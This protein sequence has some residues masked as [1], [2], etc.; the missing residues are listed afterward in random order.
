MIPSTYPFTVS[1]GAGQPIYDAV[2]DAVL[3]QRL[4]PGTKLTEARLAE[5]FGVSRTIVRMALLCLAHDHIVKLSPNR[6]ARIVSPTVAETR[7][8][9]EARRLVECAAMPLV[10]ERTAIK[11]LDELR[12]LVRQEDSAFHSGD[13]RTWIRRSGEFHIGLIALADNPVILHFGR[14]LVTQAL[15]MT[16]LYMPR[17]QTSCATGEHMALIDALADG[18]G[19]KAARLMQSHLCACEQRLNL[20]AHAE[21]A[22][23]LGRTLGVGIRGSGPA[24]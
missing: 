3:D 2:H 23:D 15:L 14:E 18:E 22:A 9:F 5:L 10:A 11:P 24:R 12:R 8:V 20:D 6:G 13:V 7:Q 17:G 21:P 19:R 16:A 1:S 4:A